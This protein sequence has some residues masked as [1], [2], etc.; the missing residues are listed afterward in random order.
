MS[1]ISESMID[2]LFVCC[3]DMGCDDRRNCD[4]SGYLRV[5][6]DCGCINTII[7][8]ELHEVKLEYHNTATKPGRMLYFEGKSRLECRSHLESMS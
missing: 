3:R 8:S 7:L 2:I 5:D 4:T 1:S 6:G